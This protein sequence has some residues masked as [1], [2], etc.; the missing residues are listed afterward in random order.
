MKVLFIALGILLLLIVSFVI[1]LVWGMNK[2]IEEE[3]KEFKGLR[4]SKENI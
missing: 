2:I 4:K 3:R 1:W